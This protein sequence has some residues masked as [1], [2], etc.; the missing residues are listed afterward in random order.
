MK[1][2]CSQSLWAQRLALVHK[3]E[4]GGEHTGEGTCAAVELPRHDAHLTSLPG[5]RGDGGATYFADACSMDAA[6]RSYRVD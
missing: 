5:R 1:Y 3:D 4:G 2:S 6:P